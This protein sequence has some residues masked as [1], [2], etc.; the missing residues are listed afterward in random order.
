LT[1]EFVETVNT[2]RYCTFTCV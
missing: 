1:S 2:Y